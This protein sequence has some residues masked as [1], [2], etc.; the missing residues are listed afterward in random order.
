MPKYAVKP[1]APGGL[2]FRKAKRKQPEQEF[3]KTVAQ[4]LDAALPASCWWTT[5]PAGG[6]GKARGGKLKAMGL[7]AGVPDVLVIHGFAPTAAQVVWIELKAPKGK[8]P[9]PVQLA[10]H[11]DLD[12][13]HGVAVHVC[14]TLDDVESALM[15]EGIP[16]NARARA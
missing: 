5:F 11:A 14:R 1:T 15:D 16:L 2:R 12:S 13:L 4:F 7:K 6:G 3:H 10:T 9:A 8:P